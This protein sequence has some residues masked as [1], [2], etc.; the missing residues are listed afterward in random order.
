M[1]GAVTGGA[2]E[3]Q[4][5]GECEVGYAVATVLAAN[6]SWRHRRSR[7]QPSVGPPCPASD[8]VSTSNALPPSRQKIGQLHDELAVAQ[9]ARVRYLMPA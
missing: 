3:A 4:R 1:Y 8:L 9:H 2:E 6:R 7:W 5:A